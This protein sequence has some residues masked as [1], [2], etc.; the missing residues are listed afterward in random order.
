M[1]TI[2]VVYPISNIQLKI[3]RK[4][5]KLPVNSSAAVNSLKN[6]GRPGELKRKKKSQA[7]VRL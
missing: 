2:T 5:F 7:I 3:Q 1:I 4:L 6:Y